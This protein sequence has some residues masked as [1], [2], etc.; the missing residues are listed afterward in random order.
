MTKTRQIFDLLYGDFVSE[1][2]VSLDKSKYK[3]FDPRYAEDLK[4]NYPEIWDEGGNIEGNNQ[5]RRLLPIVNRKNKE[6]QTPTENMAIRKREAWGA[7]H[8]DNFR[9]AGVVAQIKWFVV[10]SRGEKYMKDLIDK[11]KQK[12]S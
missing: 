5:Y 9:V 11:E 2:Q 1:E 4:K 3:I 6:A 8:K 10:G 12:Y 7:R